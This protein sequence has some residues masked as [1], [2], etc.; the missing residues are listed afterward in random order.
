[1]WQSNK[2]K[3]IR[4]GWRD[5]TKPS[6]ITQEE[7]IHTKE[8]QD[9]INGVAQEEVQPEIPQDLRGGVKKNKIRWI[10]EKEQV[11]VKAIPTSE[12]EISKI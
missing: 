2:Y 12:K 8:S 7:K 6:G 4:P 11:E 3:G 5:R 10:Q 1:M 9:L